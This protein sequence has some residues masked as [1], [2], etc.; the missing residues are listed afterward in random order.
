MTTARELSELKKKKQ[1]REYTHH[2]VNQ[3]LRWVQKHYK[4]SDVIAEPVIIVS[5]DKRRKYS[6]GGWAKARDGR[7]RPNF[8]F[9]FKKCVDFK[10]HF[11]NE[12]D[13]FNDDPVIGKRWVPTW[14]YCVRLFAAHEVAHVVELAHFYLRNPEEKDRLI[15]RFGR[16][17]FNDDHS[18]SFQ[19]VYR[20][21]RKKYV[22]GIR[23]I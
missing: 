15:K 7:W 18:G 13:W 4:I 19:K 21:L 6:Y 9:F 3:M 11:D 22:N 1:I 20:V 8:N 10:P 2:A 12:Y 17:K 23:K 5:F 14:K 16:S